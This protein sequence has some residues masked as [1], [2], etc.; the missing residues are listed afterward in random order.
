MRGRLS[1]AAIESKSIV[2]R[3]AI[4]QDTPFPRQA[5]NLTVLIRF[6]GVWIVYFPGCLFIPHPRVKIVK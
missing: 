6:Q 3:I 4:S 2:V 5:V 1:K